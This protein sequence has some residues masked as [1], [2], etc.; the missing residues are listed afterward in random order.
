MIDYSISLAVV[1]LPVIA[2][3]LAALLDL[4]ALLLLVVSYR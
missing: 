3:S 1:D 2:E 4:S